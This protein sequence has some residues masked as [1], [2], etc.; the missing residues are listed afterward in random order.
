MT[1]AQPFKAGAT[2]Q[3]ILRRAV[4]VESQPSLTRRTILWNSNRGLK[5]TA[6]LTPA[7][8]VEEHHAPTLEI[9]AGSGE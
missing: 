7:L 6:K 1:L 8:R 4:T 9:N 2:S 3:K 5:A